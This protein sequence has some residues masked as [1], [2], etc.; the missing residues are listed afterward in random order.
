M[1]SGHP[2]ATYL[3]P[4]DAGHRRPQEN[5]S[6]FDRRHKVDRESH[7]ASLKTL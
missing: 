2:G 7:R 1:G 6:G 5:E 3:E 4:G